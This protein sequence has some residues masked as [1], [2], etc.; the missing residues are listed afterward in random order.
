[1]VDPKLGRAPPGT[2]F[3]RPHR[4]EGIRIR[5][6]CAVCS[7]TGTGVVPRY[8][9]GVRSAFVALLHKGPSARVAGPQD[10][11]IIQARLETTS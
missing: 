6:A 4:T 11:A 8:R 7:P 9:T 3:A 5:R 10:E 2:A 1:M